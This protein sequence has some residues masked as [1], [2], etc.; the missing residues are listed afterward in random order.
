MMSPMVDRFEKLLEAVI[1]FRDERDWAQFHKPKDL[2]LGM[3]VEASELSELFLWKDEAEVEAALADPSIRERLGEEMA[4]VQIFLLY[5]AHDA[6]IDLCR[7]AEDKIAKNA[8][9]YPVEKARG[10]AR[11]YSEL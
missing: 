6:G 7:A 9:K 10:S 1:R 5:L 11:K 3:G 8:A 2:A 4:D